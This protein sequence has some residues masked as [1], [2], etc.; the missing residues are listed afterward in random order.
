[1]FAAFISSFLLWVFEKFLLHFSIITH[2]F[3]I[4]LYVFILIT[5]LLVGMLGS[6]IALKKYLLIDEELL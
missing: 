4:A 6:Q 3:N 5:G 2:P 1:F